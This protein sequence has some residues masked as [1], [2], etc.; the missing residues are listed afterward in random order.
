MA[1]GAPIQT[2]TKILKNIIILQNEELFESKKTTPF[3]KQKKTFEKN[4]PSDLIEKQIKM[5]FLMAT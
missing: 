4:F 1:R 2:S 5:F 3:V